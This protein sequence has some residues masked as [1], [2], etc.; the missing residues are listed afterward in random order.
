MYYQD[1]DGNQ[2]ETQVD[3]FDNPDDA[4]AMSTC[5]NE[6]L[7]DS[8]YVDNMWSLKRTESTITL[9]RSFLDTS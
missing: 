7:A 3:N 8:N 9:Y 6:Q 2:L 5:A 4:T 1:P